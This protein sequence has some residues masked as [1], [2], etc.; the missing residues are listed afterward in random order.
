MS[1]A[2]GPAADASS[3]D[4]RTSGGRHLLPWVL[5]LAAVALAVAAGAWWWTQ[6]APALTAT[7]VRADGAETLVVRAPDAAPGSTVRLGVTEG[8]VERGEARLPL[9]PD[10]LHV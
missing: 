4:D 3:A 8:R 1:S 5:G 7:V 6:R 9:E 2:S 10:A